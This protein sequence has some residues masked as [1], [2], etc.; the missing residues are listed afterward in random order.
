MFSYFAQ[1]MYAQQL[2]IFIAK[3]YSMQ[4]ADCFHLLD[5]PDTVFTILKYL[6]LSLLYK[7]N[8]QSRQLLMLA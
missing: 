7:N 6:H 2:S 5:N 8:P 3:S 1:K 4:I